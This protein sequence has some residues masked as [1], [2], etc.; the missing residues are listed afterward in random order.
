[1]AGSVSRDRVDRERA[2]R[3]SSPHYVTLL[4]LCNDV[5]RGRMVVASMIICFALGAAL[6]RLAQPRTYTARASFTPDVVR[7]VASARGG[8]SALG[9]VGGAAL[10]FDPSRTMQLPQAG[11]TSQIPAST[12][13]I[14]PLD[15]AF[16][17][18]L[19]HSREILLA[20]AGSRFSI[21]TPTGARTGSAADVYALPPGPAGPRLED[22]ARR[23]DREMEVTF[24]DPTGVLTLS[25]RTFDPQF[26]RA[27]AERML[28]ALREQN[29]RMSEARG[30]AQVLSLTRAMLE[31]RE[32][33]RVAQ[34]GFAGFLASNR[35]FLSTSWLALEFHRRDAEVLEKRQQYSDL[36]VQLERAKLDQ[37]RATQFISVVARPETP[38]GPDPRG[39][40][41]ATV[42]GAVG[43]AALS[44]LIVLVSA[45]VRRLRAAGY[46]D[47][48]ALEDEWRAVRRFTSPRRIAVSSGVA[49]MA[50]GESV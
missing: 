19:M 30:D 47:L 33:L 49:P 21:A 32:E 22:A 23:L 28:D 16:Y 4:G 29:R 43:G 1:M 14:E 8:L 48:A 34:N 6:F 9:G 45:H 40:L 18:S 38:S 10:R 36:A 27:V 41:R 42:A 5:L 44:V 37:A 17:W 46:H 7:P 3:A 24:D 13:P 11:I 35:A 25:V 26:A 12:A 15:P 31:A 2:D 20:V 50:P 39:V